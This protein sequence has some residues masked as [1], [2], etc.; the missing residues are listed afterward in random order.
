MNWL[1]G[2]FFPVLTHLVMKRFWDTN[3]MSQNR[4]VARFGSLNG[5][6]TCFRCPETVSRQLPCRGIVPSVCFWPK[7]GPLNQFAR[8]STGIYRGTILC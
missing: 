6:G 8:L 7:G 2:F 1:E 3:S 5:F 4:F